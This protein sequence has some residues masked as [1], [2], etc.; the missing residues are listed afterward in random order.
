MATKHRLERRHLEPSRRPSDTV[1]HVAC[2]PRT[3]RRAVSFIAERRRD[4]TLR[5]LQKKPVLKYPLGAAAEQPRRPPDL[6]QRFPGA[7]VGRRCKR[8][9]NLAPQNARRGRL[10][11][12][13]RTTKNEPDA[14]PT[15]TGAPL[16]LLRRAGPSAEPA[17]PSGVAATRGKRLYLE[18]EKTS[19]DCGPDVLAPGRGSIMSTETPRS[20]TGDVARPNET[21]SRCGPETADYR[22]DRR[23]GFAWILRA[24]VMSRD[25]DSFTVHTIHNT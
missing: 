23:H 1:Q 16:R 10:K 6:V 8:D 17:S 20:I 2:L 18:P 15:L 21:T 3:R 7:H 9:Q 11:D 5:D 4:E 25:H 14:A 12:P 24:G 19:I 22:L 13:T